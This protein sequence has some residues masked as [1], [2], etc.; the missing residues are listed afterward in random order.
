M[1][2]NQTTRV[3][4]T[5]TWSLSDRGVNAL[6]P[7][8]KNTLGLEQKTVV[9]SACCNEGEYIPLRKTGFLW[10]MLRTTHYRGALGGS[11]G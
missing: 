2:N 6:Q 5:V 3:N 1:C 10:K 9:F 11:V 8:T 7:K 4:G